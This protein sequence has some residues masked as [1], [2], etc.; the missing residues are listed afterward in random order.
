MKFG[1]LA[2]DQALGGVLAHAISRPG[3]SL[4]KGERIGAEQ[5]AALRNAGVDEIVVAIAEEGDVE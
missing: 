5:I 3:L 4:R 2:I 1:P